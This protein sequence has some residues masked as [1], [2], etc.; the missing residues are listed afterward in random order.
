MQTILSYG[1]GV[2]STAI[3]IRW[4]EEASF[5][6]CPLDEV[7]L[8]TAHT[9][10]EYEDT[11][12]DV[13]SHVLP[14][15]RKHHIR[16][17]QLARAGHRQ[18][19]GIVVLSD[20]RNPQRLFLEGAYKLS[21]ELRAAGTVPQFGEEHICSLKFKAWVIEPWLAEHIP[22]PL[23]HAFGYNAEETKRVSKS[24]TAEARRIAFGF[25][26]DET[27]RATK[28]AGYDTA[29]RQSFYPLVE[30]GW[31]RKHCVEYLHDR[32][33]VSW[34][35]SACVQC[36]FNALK[37]EALARH[38]EHPEQVAQ[39]MML[40]HVS[41]A[42]NPRG[43]LYRA[44]S[45]IEI[46]S[47][48]GNTA[49]TDHFRLDLRQQPWTIY[50]VRRV[51]HAGKDRSGNICPDKKGNAIRSVECV[52]QNADRETMFANLRALAGPTDE[53]VEQR[54]IQY[55][56]RSRCQT[57][58]PTREE[59]FVAAPAVVKPKARYGMEWFERQWAVPQMS[60]FD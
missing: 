23:R 30:W 25:N 10:D 29:M 26:A 32:L 58:Y 47:A 37:E 4:L 52:A 14:R 57:T 3:L 24:E 15:L 19:D 31:T 38:K 56:Y 50:R 22:V 35:K 44:Q 2:E 53:M 43:T 12:R 16:Y 40:E 49:A 39:A 60:L 11:R 5:R 42:L 34:K 54:G 36:P 27:K 6:P 28:A 9:G 33:Q 7:I 13:E 51:Y 46:T 1:L 55:V 21:D 8:I 59:F 45:L 20:S 18:A 17:V 41:L 48:N